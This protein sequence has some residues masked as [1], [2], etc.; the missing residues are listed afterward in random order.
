VR[1]YQARGA[2]IWTPQHVDVTLDG[3]IRAHTP[4]RVHV[5]PEPIRV[6]LPE[7]L[8]SRETTDSGE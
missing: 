3:E 5:A 8:E 1:R 6:L 2:V 7:Q 4:V